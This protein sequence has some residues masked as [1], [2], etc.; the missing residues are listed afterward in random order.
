MMKG[1]EKDIG[2]ASDLYSR[3]LTHAR[4]NGKPLGEILVQETY[5]LWDAFAHVAL[6]DDCIH[7]SFSRRFADVEKKYDD[8]FRSAFR[9]GAFFIGLIFF[10]ITK[11]AVLL[12]VVRRHRVLVFSVD[13]ISS[14][15]YSADFRIEKIYRELQKHHVPFIEF[16]HTLVQARSVTHLGTR[17][18]FA[19]YLEGVDW[20]FFVL[21]SIR[22]LVVRRDSQYEIT[23]FESFTADEKLFAQALVRKYVSVAPLVSFRISFLRAVLRMSGVRVIVG[24]DDAR[25][26]HELAAA[27]EDLKIPFYA[28]Q[29][30]SGHFSPYHVGWLRD[31]RLKGKRMYPGTIMVWNEYWKQELFRLNVLW[32][33]DQI[34]VGGQAKLQTDLALVRGATHDPIL[35]PYEVDASPVLVRSYIEALGKLKIPIIFK[36]RGD[37]ARAPQEKV[38]EGIAVPVSIESV[39]TRPV[40]AV[41]GMYSTLLYDSVACGI[42]VGVLASPLRHAEGMLLHGLAESIS[43]TTLGEDMKCLQGLSSAELER[44]KKVAEPADFEEEFVHVLKEHGVV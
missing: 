11:I 3:I 8:A 28:Y 13:K 32:K 21:R 14:K 2:Y 33:G 41:V 34:R 31:H 10:A 22:R 20:L 24:I 1:D 27:A 17:K 25:Y 26:Y 39:V 18:R 7:F 37:I 29:H 40:S 44:R 4:V 9:G 12:L 23:G 16:F 19:L 5:N 38:L 43:L 6:F 15:K 36:I 35:I 30:G 42:P